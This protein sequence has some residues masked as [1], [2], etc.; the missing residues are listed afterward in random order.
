VVVT[1]RNSDPR[2][3]G[4]T[5][6]N[7]L[8]RLRELKPLDEKFGAE[9]LRDLAPDV[10]DP[11]GHEALKLSRQIGGL[12]IAL[13]LAGACLASPWGQWSSFAGYNRALN[14]D[15]SSVV[16]DTIVRREVGLALDT[17]TAGG[18]PQARVLLLALSCFTLATPVPAWLLDQPPLADLLTHPED[19]YPERAGQHENLEALARLG[20]IETSGREDLASINAVTVP[21]LVADASRKLLS[22]M[23]DAEREAILDTAA[24]M[25]EAAV[26]ELDPARPDDQTTWL[27]LAPHAIE[28]LA[29]GLGPATLT[30]LLAACAVGTNALVSSG[31][32]ATAGKLAQAS[33]AA[34]AL[35]SPGTEPRAL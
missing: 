19:Q 8:I 23:T 15:Q 27:L 5:I 34:A 17:L 20:L 6:R 28:L 11:G 30:R 16:P 24:R 3:W 14:R 35:L 26:A 21:A 9:L 4:A 13:H 2:V 12:P 25:L 32:M 29:S 31:W 1:T 10:V 22:A 33:V 18:L 7:P